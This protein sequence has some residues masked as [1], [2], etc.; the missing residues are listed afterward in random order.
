ME[1]N[2]KEAKRKRAV[3]LSGMRAQTYDLMRNLLS[4]SKPGDRS[5]E[6][7]VKLLKDYFQPK[8]IKIMQRWIFNARNRKPD[9]SV[10]DYVT[11]LRKLTQDCNISDSSTVM[12][13]DWLVCSI[14]DEGVQWKLLV[15][16]TLT[17]IKH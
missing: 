2:I 17:L 14:D 13:K 4:P 5:Y 15:E 8:T 11:A 7:L 1:N 3:L 12:L 16:D 6:D 10:S 9:K